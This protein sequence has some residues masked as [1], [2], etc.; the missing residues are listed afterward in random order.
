LIVDARELSPDHTIYADICIIGA[1]V[2]G[3][4]LAK[5]LMG[6]GLN[7]CLLE[8]GGIE[9]DR[10]TQALCRGKNI[11]HPYYPLDTARSRNFGGSSIKWLLELGDNQ[12]GARLQALDA[13]DFE[14]REWIE[15]SGWPF[16]KQHLDPYYTRAQQLCKVAVD[17]YNLSDWAESDST[18]SIPFLG[19]RVGTSIYYC[20]S[21]EVF[22]KDYY[23]E[24]E[25]APNVHVY[26][27]ANALEIETDKSGK[28]VINLR[29]ACLGGKEFFVNSNQFVVAVGGIETPRLLLLSN[30]VQKNGIGNQNDLVG[31]FFMEHPHLLSGTFVPKEKILRKKMGLYKIHQVRGQP[32]IGQLKLNEKTILK[33][34]MLNDAVVLTPAPKPYII[35]SQSAASHGVKS[36][37][38]AVS[39]LFR[40]DIDEFNRHLSALFPVVN[41]FSINAYRKAMDAIYI[42][43]GTIKESVFILHHMAEQIPNPD[44]RI[45]LASEKDVLGQNLVQLDWTLSSQDIHSIRRTQEIIDE[46]LQRADIGRVQIDLEGETPPL[47][48]TGGWHHM[49]TTRM[50][51]DPKYGVVDKNCCVHGISNLYIAGPSIFPTSGC[52]NPTLTIIAL[53]LR[54][55]DHLK[56]TM[57]KS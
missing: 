31:R 54:L 39:A 29:A 22:T 45:T 57:A 7:I 52:A 23:K 53:A 42:L 19:D 11:G 25:D 13:I 2:S 32:I 37:G 21:R 34:R 18:P 38:L 40:R 43:F 12:L 10:K 8:S 35:G 48:I 44:S 36:L 46:E 41:E 55:A 33:E 9:P 3:I 47:E 51:V 17:N 16:S 15:Y 50:H 5:E 56:Q 26:L 24:L 30:K 20:L 4:T 49:G 1:G 6:T 28:Q 14:K 27:Y